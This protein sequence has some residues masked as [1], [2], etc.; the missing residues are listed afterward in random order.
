MTARAKA[1]KA[2]SGAQKTPSAR[3]ARKVVETQ[4]VETAVRRVVT[5]DIGSVHTRVALYDLVEGQF[6][7][8]GR[9]QALTTAAP[10]GHDVSEGLRRA[11]AELGALSGLN[12]L[13]ADREQR[14][15]MGEEYGNTFVA[16]ASGGKPIRA[17]LVGLM[18]N[19]SL[20]SG[21]RALES[22]YVELVD[23]LDLLDVRTPEQQVNAILR[24]APDLILIVGG[25]NSGANAPM[26]A[27]I[28]T[29]RLAV[30]LAPAMKPVVLYA[31]NA[32]LSAFVREQLEGRVPLYI[33]ENV[34]PSLERESFD[35]I[36]LE[37]AFLY[38][39]YRA[40]TTPGFKI[41][42]D[43]SKLGVLPSVESY[44]NIVRYLADASGK[45]RNVLLVDVGSSTVTVCAM[46]RGALNVTI[47]SD[48]GLGHSAVSGVEAVGVRN[49]ARWLTFEPAPSEIMDYAWNKTLRPATVPEIGRELELEYALAR[50]LI[51]VAMQTSRQG[52][53]GV[54][55]NAPLPPMRLIIGVGSVL[56]QPINAGMGALLLLDALQPLG[57]VDLRLDP[58]GVIASMG[59][60]IHLEPLMVVQV[61]ETGG[62]L[63]LATAI[64]PSGKASGTALE[65]RITYA[66]GRSREVRVPSNTLRVVPVPIGQRARVSLKLGRGLRLNG[67]RRL[68]FEVQGSAVGLLFDTRGR[69]LVLPRDP[70]KRAE[71]LP[72]WYEAVQ[73]GG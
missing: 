12:F 34:R 27:L 65:A 48:L 72:K 45:K 44:G 55:I 23:A 64:C 42:Q 35:P 5:A 68:S 50:E 3:S 4:P 67:K 51:R 49:I 10:R 25:T 37:L 69:P 31:G 15:L 2:E 60:L 39:D 29:V 22:T 33:T 61:L 26:R 19:I 20:E 54:P 46:V 17:V 21:K 43:A 47:R 36:R 52:W 1:P 40:R 66:D 71:L 6:R 59:S 18:P 24:A 70:S 73:E 8:V 7:L 38:G 57:I 56:A 14:L 28:E 30:Q 53:Q 13:S 58:Y 63:N 62:L 41:V 9:A 11:L 16:T 32:A